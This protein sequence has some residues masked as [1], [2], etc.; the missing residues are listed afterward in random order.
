MVYGC[1]YLLPLFIVNS[2]HTI[3]TF[4]GLLS[5]HVLTFLSPV[6]VIYLTTGSALHYA[7]LRLMTVTLFDGILDEHVIYALRLFI[8]LGGTCISCGRTV[9]DPNFLKSLLSPQ[10]KHFNHAAM[11]HTASMFFRVIVPMLAVCALASCTFKVL[12]QRLKRKRPAES[13]SS[14]APQANTVIKCYFLV[15][16]LVVL[17]IGALFISRSHKSE[18]AV[19]IRLYI[20]TPMF[21]ILMPMFFILSNRSISGHMEKRAKILFSRL[22]PSRV[23]PSWP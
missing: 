17:S 11:M 16:V 7:H 20:S 18:T 14:P 19:A 13:P 15:A 3:P 5:F 6:L 21:C 12:G 1:V 10:L 9:L 23:G 22:V 4:L 8:L 2:G